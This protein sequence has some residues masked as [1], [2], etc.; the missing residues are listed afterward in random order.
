MGGIL[1][2]AFSLL[3]PYSRNKFKFISLEFIFVF[4][5]FSLEFVAFNIL[6]ILNRF[7]K[8][9]CMKQK[10]SDRSCLRFYLW[11]SFNTKT[12][13]ISNVNAHSRPAAKLSRHG[14]MA[15]R[16][17][18]VTYQPMSFSVAVFLTL[19]DFTFCSDFH[20]LRG[21]SNRYISREGLSC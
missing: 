1:T 21:V 14:A 15:L 17:L 11:Q 6:H 7:W 13:R 10:I 2:D 5:I 16:N 4:C 12:R 20:S 19:A 3:L 9:F 8:R 18:P